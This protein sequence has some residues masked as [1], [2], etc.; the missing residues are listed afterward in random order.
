MTWLQ[1]NQ[2]NYDFINH[3]MERSYKANDTIFCYCDIN[4]NLNMTSLKTEINKTPLNARYDIKN[5]TKDRFD[6][7]EDENTIWFNSYDYTNI[8]GY[9]NKKNNYGVSYSYYDLEKENIDSITQDTSLLAEKTLKSSDYVGNIVKDFNMVLQN[10]VYSDFSKAIVQ[11][12]YLKTNFFSFSI[13]IN[14]NPLSQ[15]K[16][17]D[18]LNVLIPSMPNY[19]EQEINDIYSGKYIVGA[20]VYSVGRN[21]I[22]QK[23]LVLFRD[24][25][26]DSKYTEKKSNNK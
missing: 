3:V 4:K 14:I 23:Q 24:G 9:N 10:N 17:F 21:N 1:L 20:N 15:V 16:L 25:M 7:T 26:D 19:V 18:V 12:K 13:S 22:F 2:S 5:Y 11:N 8:S 6:N